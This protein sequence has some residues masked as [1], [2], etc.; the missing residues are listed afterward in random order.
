[1]KAH[2]LVAFSAL[3]IGTSAIAAEN[4]PLEVT[5][6]FD[7]EWRCTTSANV[8]IIEDGTVSTLPGFSFTLTLK[9]A[10]LKTR[11]EA[12]FDKHPVLG[13]Y[14]L[15]SSIPDFKYT[16]PRYRGDV[17]VIPG[18]TT[19]RLMSK[20]EHL[21]QGKNSYNTELH[22]VVLDLHIKEDTLN[23]TVYTPSLTMRAEGQ[24]V[25]LYTEKGACH[26]DKK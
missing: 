14:L 25:S 23:Y 22:N 13:Q 7:K 9:Q 26:S 24:K 20:F 8:M 2:W 6:H 16:Q 15:S 3:S 18:F 21:S 19:G 11:V 10:T 4:L 12:H 5:E 1:M 17:I